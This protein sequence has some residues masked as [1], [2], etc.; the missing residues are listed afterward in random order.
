MG[1]SITEGFCDP[2]IELSALGPDTPWRGWADRLAIILDGNA[3]LSGTGIEFANLAVRSRRIDDVVDEQIPVAIDLGA[4]LVSVMVGGNDLMRPAADPDALAS[5]LESGIAALRASGATVLLANC[6]DPQF[7]LFLRPF[8]G[9]A[10]VFN[11][12]VWSIA[13]AH[14]VSVLDLWGIREF[15]SSSMWAA[16]RVHLSSAG[17]RLLAVRA[18]HVLGVPYA[19]IAARLPLNI[20]T[21]EA[22]SQ[23]G[24]QVPLPTWLRRYAIPW[25]VRMMRGVTAGDGLSPKLPDPSPI[26][27][28]P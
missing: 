9:R 20:R 17:H 18:A 8:R 1:D 27:V 3:R 11:A 25:A 10:A 14:G 12:N 5:R 24:E 15:Q 13:R 26:R 19:E 16:D 4:D 28:R 7:A 23:P 21:A 22:D 2:V 6:F